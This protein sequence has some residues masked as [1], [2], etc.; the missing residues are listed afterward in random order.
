MHKNS[1]DLETTYLVA[2]DKSILLR[3]R[4]R[5][6]R[7]EDLSGAHGFRRHILRGGRRNWKGPHLRELEA[8]KHTHP[9]T[10]LRFLDLLRAKGSYSSAHTSEAYTKQGIDTHDEKKDATESA[11]RAS[12]G[13]HRREKDLRWELC[14]GLGRG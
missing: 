11:I 3:F 2:K 8:G 10:H 7:Q 5:C 1:G 6:P 4:H 14:K 13:K 12:R 9:F